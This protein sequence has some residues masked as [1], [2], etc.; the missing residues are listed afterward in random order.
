MSIHNFL[1]GFLSG[2]Q[3]SARC[4][5]SGGG[6]PPRRTGRFAAGGVRA[7]ACPGVVGAPGAAVAPATVLIAV[8]EALYVPGHA[9]DDLSTTLCSDVKV[10]FGSKFGTELEAYTGGTDQYLFSPLGSDNSCCSPI[11]NTSLTPVLFCRTRKQA[12][13]RA[14]ETLTR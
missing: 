4:G 3:N 1:M 12:K 11:E 10:L 14:S 8:A 9:K 5:L 7:P 6:L 13:H 2:R